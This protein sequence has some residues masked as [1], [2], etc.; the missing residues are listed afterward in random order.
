MSL[1]SLNANG[2][3]EKHQA[4]VGHHPRSGLRRR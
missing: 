4:A 1:Y 3:I 2:E